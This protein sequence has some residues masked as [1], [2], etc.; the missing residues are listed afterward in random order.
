MKF[1]EGR[2]RNHKVMTTSKVFMAKN[3]WN[4]FHIPLYFELKQKIPVYIVYTTFGV[5]K[6]WNQSSVKARE[7]SYSPFKGSL[8]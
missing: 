6:T 5:I 1:T 2:E 3:V 8:N 7:K 4:I